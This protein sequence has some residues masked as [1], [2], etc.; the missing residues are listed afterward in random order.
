MQVLVLSQ[1][2]DPTMPIAD[3]MVVWPQTS[4]ACDA[5]DDEVKLP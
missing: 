2:F 4:T 3:H 5:D 1:A